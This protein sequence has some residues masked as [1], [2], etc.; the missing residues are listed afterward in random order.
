MSY[1]CLCADTWPLLSVINVG[2]SLSM[3]LSMSSKDISWGPGVW[4]DPTT[5]GDGWR[6]KV[7]YFLFSCEDDPAVCVCVRVCVR[8]RARVCTRVGQWIVKAP[9]L[10]CHLF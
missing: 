1:S 10:R 6:E 9:S 4:R 2:L 5:V 8:A 7:M 3:S